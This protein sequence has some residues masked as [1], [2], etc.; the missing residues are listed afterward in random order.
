PK[1]EWDDKTFLI[2]CDAPAPRAADD[3]EL[4]LPQL[5]RLLPATRR[6]DHCTGAAAD[7]P[8]GLA[9]RGGISAGK[10][11]VRAAGTVP[12]VKAVSPRASERRRLRVSRRARTVPD[13]CEVRR[14]GQ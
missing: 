6:R 2:P 8:A 1:V 13:S 5:R 14:S 9:A 7:H 4:E 11:A 10:A 3:P 12:L